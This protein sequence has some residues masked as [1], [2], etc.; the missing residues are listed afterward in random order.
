MRK[1]ETLTGTAGFL[2]P[3]CPCSGP[4]CGQKP[5]AGLFISCNSGP[6]RP[7][8][9]LRQKSF[10]R[11]W[12][13]SVSW[14]CPSFWVRI[15]IT[16]RLPPQWGGI[17]SGLLAWKKLLFLEKPVLLERE[18]RR[19]GHSR[20]PCVGLTAALLAGYRF[21]AAFGHSPRQSAF[22]AGSPSTAAPEQQATCSLI[23][24]VPPEES[25]S[26]VRIQS[27]LSVVP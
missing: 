27:P 12:C 5:G 9:G 10:A 25:F 19:E 14:E 17:I 11:P 8:G 22:S 26:L 6:L 20:V 21:R 18:R 15:V 23:F 24:H 4:Q 13:S 2:C 3:A 16:P 1:L 7:G